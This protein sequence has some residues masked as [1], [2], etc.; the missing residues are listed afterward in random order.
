MA[1]DADNKLQNPETPENALVTPKR[2]Y[3][4][5]PAL[6]ALIDRIAALRQSLL[7]ADKKSLADATA[8]LEEAKNELEASIKGLQDALN[9]NTANDEA[10][11]LRIKQNEDD[12]K[13]LQDDLAAYK[14]TVNDQLDA[15]LAA[16]DT[17]V[18]AAQVEAAY[19]AAIDDKTDK[20]DDAEETPAE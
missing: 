16:L 3:V 13:D 17:V 18:T 9:S 12:I 5:A 4:D 11:E 2:A 19:D 8:G 20:T 10:R 15:I 6:Q 7:E 14:T 1:L